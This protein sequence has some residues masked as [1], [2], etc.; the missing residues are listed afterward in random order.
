MQTS[1]SVS[2]LL[3]AT[4]AAIAGTA[5][6]AQPPDVGLSG[7]TTGPAGTALAG[8]SDAV[9][10]PLAT[11]RIT[12]APAT[13]VEGTY[14]LPAALIAEPGAERLAR[15]SSEWSTASTLYIRGWHPQER[16]AR[17]GVGRSRSGR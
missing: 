11:I 15:T 8:G 4:F 17:I 16:P 5:Y 13:A 10:K 3:A 14:F 1:K 6:G 2:L 7:V 9:P 12:S